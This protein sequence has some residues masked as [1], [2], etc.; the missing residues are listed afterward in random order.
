LIEPES[1]SS[2][3]LRI[4]FGSK[5]NSIKSISDEVIYQPAKYKVLFGSKASENLRA[6]FKVVK[7]PRKVIND[8]DLKVRIVSSI[9]EF[10]DV[11]NWD[12]GDTF[13]LGELITFILNSVAPDV[14]NLVVVPRQLSQEF[15]DLFEIQSRPDEIFVSGATVDDIEIV[16]SLVGTQIYGRN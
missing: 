11:N 10:F 5:L 9:N 3:S 16:P 7:N 2:D 6:I 14:S 4:S 13:Y 15:G 1:P 8:N 12:F